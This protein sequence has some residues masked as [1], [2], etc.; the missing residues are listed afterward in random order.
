MFVILDLMVHVFFLNPC[1]RIFDFN[2]KNKN[3]MQRYEFIFIIQGHKG[4]EK[5]INHHQRIIAVF[6]FLK[7]IFPVF[8]TKNIYTS[9]YLS[10]KTCIFAIKNDMFLKKTSKKAF[11]Y[12]VQPKI[13]K[14]LIY[15]KSNIYDF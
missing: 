4:E 11:F 15:C 12:V 6:R 1:E 9:Q 14:I 13:N 8:G 5:T 10:L 7:T 3:T 2:N